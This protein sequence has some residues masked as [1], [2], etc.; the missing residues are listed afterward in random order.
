MTDERQ[1]NSPSTTQAVAMEPKIDHTGEA[2]P[3]AQ[4]LPVAIYNSTAFALS[5]LLSPYLVIP[6][7]TVGIVASTSSA[8]ADFLRWTFFSV[9]FSTIVPALY[10]VM[11][12]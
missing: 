5:A 4:P 8:R 6:A 10:V 12:I 11:Q 9:L 1:E 2:V 3:I 7:G